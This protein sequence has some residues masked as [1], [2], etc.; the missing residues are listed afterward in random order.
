MIKRVKTCVRAKF[1]L[2]DLRNMLRMAVEIECKN[3]C[4]C[5]AL[6]VQLDPIKKALFV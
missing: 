3:A 1:G 4:S 6:M 5:K 2:Q